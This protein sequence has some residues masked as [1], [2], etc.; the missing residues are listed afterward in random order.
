[1]GN[2]SGTEE[3]NGLSNEIIAIFKSLDGLDEKDKD[4]AVL[5]MGGPELLQLYYQ[6]ASTSSDMR[7]DTQPGAGGILGG[8]QGRTPGAGGMLGGERSRMPNNMGRGR[9]SGNLMDMFG[10]GGRG[11]MPGMGG[12]MPGMGGG[13]PGMGGGI[14]GM[15]GSIPGMEEGSEI[16]QEQTMQILQQFQMIEAMSPNDKEQ[17]L[18]A[19]GGQE[20]VQTYNEKIAPMMKQLGIG[21]GQGGLPGGG[22]AVHGTSGLFGGPGAGRGGG[23]IGPGTNRVGN[24]FGGQVGGGGMFGGQVPAGAGD[25]FG[26]GGQGGLGGLF[27]AGGNENRQS[28]GTRNRQRPIDPKTIEGLGNLS[29]EDKKAALEAMGNPE[30][31]QQVNQSQASQRTEDYEPPDQPYEPIGDGMYQFHRRQPLQLPIHGG[32]T[33]SRPQNICMM[34]VTRKRRFG[35]KDLVR[36]H[37][38]SIDLE[39]YF[40]HLLDIWTKEA[41]ECEDPICNG[42]STILLLDISESMRGEPIREAVDGI[43]KYIEGLEHN[44]QRYKVEENVALIVFHGDTFDV[45]HLTNDYNRIIEVLDNL[46]EVIGASPLIMPL[47]VV[48]GIATRAKPVKVKGHDILT[49]VVI[50]SDVFITPPGFDPTQEEYV[51]QRVQNSMDANFFELT[52][53]LVHDHNVR[54][55]A[56]PTGRKSRDKREWFCNKIARDGFGEK[57]LP[58]DARWL[59]RN[60]ICEKIIAECKIKL[61]QFDTE[62]SED[63][64]DDDCI[65]EIAKSLNFEVDEDDIDFI[66]KRLKEKLQRPPLTK[67]QRQEKRL[68]DEMDR[69]VAIERGENPPPLPPDPS[70]KHKPEKKGRKSLE[71]LL[72]IDSDDD[73]EDGEEADIMFRLPGLIG[74]DDA[75]NDPLTKQKIEELLAYYG[76]GP[77][78]NDNLPFMPSMGTRVKIGPDWM[79]Q[80]NNLPENIIGTIISIDQEDRGWVKVKW[81]QIPGSSERELEEDYRFGVDYEFDVEPVNGGMDAVKWPAGKERKI[82]EPI[83][84]QELNREKEELTELRAKLDLVRQREQ[85]KSEGKEMKEEQTEP[86]KKETEIEKGMNNCTTQTTDDNG[87]SDVTSVTSEISQDVCYVWQYRADDGTWKTYDTDAQTKLE[88]NYV[89]RN[90][91]GTVLIEFEGHNERVIFDKM[92]QRPIEQST[93]REIRRI[94]ADADRL[95]ELQDMFSS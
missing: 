48:Q 95:K 79:W 32:G 62:N 30:L 20:Y 68:Q 58:E 25:L 39:G 37:G 12:G 27:G 76:G 90:G 1:M 36:T 35:E 54:M 13:M 52:Q 61:P 70:R 16:S 9:G 91:K 34:P 11:G 63:K 51:R 84:L 23:M 6:Y 71:E 86:V 49:R 92:E 7:F 45:T 83:W 17:A 59:S 75:E 77:T 38:S 80:K 65:E 89:K 24:M 73:E 21:I 94:E 72:G 2:G 85:N 18:L 46:K 57:V 82:F 60:Y 40:K 29:E 69:A 33:D 88:Q 4:A 10:G 78:Q 42:P 15:G 56:V 8:G 26:T 31:T 14:P 22:G 53:D 28:S 5:A 93:K 43:R 55:F 67:R 47:A 74:E 50:F 19:I 66:V 41:Q 44:K 87:W 64:P 81:D 3:E